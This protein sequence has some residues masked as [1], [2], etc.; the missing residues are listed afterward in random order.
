[1]AK[2]K[3]EGTVKLDGDYG[4]VDLSYFTN[5]ELRR[6]KQMSGLR[7]GEFD[8][9]FKK[10]DND[11]MVAFAVVV[12]ERRGLANVEQELWGAVAGGITFDFTDEEQ[13]TDADP[14]VLT[15]AG[16]PPDEPKTGSGNGSSSETSSVSL[17]R[18]ES[19]Q[20]HIGAQT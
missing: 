7:L 6:I 14:P 20:S 9:A 12:L 1:M 16:E 3:I 15:P 2:L 5:D 18:L 19:D 13:E 17:A 4:D 10:G 8:E 11:I